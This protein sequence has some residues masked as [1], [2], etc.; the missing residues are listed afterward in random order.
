MVAAEKAAVV[1]WNKA[2]SDSLLLGVV[3]TRLRTKHSSMTLA[4]KQWLDNAKNALERLKA[5]PLQQ[6][7]L[8]PTAAAL[9]VAE[10]RA[11]AAASHELLELI[12]TRVC[13][14]PPKR[15]FVLDAANHYFLA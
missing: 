1:A 7:L 12:A 4:R 2:W 3:A 13:E 10:M 11:I 14:T 6:A 9:A 5:P 15:R 8:A